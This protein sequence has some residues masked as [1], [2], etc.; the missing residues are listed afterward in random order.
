MRQ[1]TD[2]HT[3]ILNHGVRKCK[4]RVNTGQMAAVAVIRLLAGL[5][6]MNSN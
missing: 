1:V 5:A 2:S 3:G 6:A 4:P